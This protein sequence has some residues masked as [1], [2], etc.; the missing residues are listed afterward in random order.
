MNIPAKKR[1]NR[2]EEEDTTT[3]WKRQDGYPTDVHVKISSHL[4][5]EDNK[6]IHIP[7]DISL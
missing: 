4:E 3:D 6:Q 5:K 2:A 7:R 1:E